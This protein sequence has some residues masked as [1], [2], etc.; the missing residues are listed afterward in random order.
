MR[1]SRSTYLL[2]LVEDHPYRLGE[3]PCEE[4]SQLRGRMGRCT[5]WRRRD[6][7]ESM[8]C[9]ERGRGEGRKKVPVESQV[10]EKH[11][12]CWRRAIC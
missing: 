7:R 6:E 10:I 9:V 2:L 1:L 11:T 5:E 12:C 3:D 8:D 4:D